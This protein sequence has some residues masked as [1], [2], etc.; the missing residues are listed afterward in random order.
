MPSPNGWHTLLASGGKFTRCQPSGTGFQRKNFFFLHDKHL[1]LI[2]KIKSH[3]QGSNTDSLQAVSLQALL[4]DCVFFGL[5]LREDSTSEKPLKPTY[6]AQFMVNP[7][8]P[9]PANE[10]ADLHSTPV[11]NLLSVNGALYKVPQKQGPSYDEK[12]DALKRE[13]K[14]L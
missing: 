5:K 9:S 3:S 12:S 4:P 13:I 8:L 7:C 14:I 11:N 2:P 1:L 6:E 10:D